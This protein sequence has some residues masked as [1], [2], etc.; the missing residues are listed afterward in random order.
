LSGGTVSGCERYETV[1][2]SGP[3]NNW[4]RRRECPNRGAVTQAQIDP[5]AIT[6]ILN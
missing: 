6:L 2:L 3:T 4:S 1:Q 5:P